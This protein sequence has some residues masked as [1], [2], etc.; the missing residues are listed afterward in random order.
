MFYKQIALTIIP[1]TSNIWKN[2]LAKTLSKPQTAT[3]YLAAIL[4]NKDISKKQSYSFL[5]Q[6][7][8]VANKLEIVTLILEYS[9]LYKK[10]TQKL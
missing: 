1:Y 6:Q 8:V 4:L 5:K 9:T 2:V 10:I 7:H 3:S